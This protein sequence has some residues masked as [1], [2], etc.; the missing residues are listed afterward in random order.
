MIYAQDY[1]FS[2]SFFEQWYE[3]FKKVPRMGLNQSNQSN[4]PYAN[5]TESVKDVYLSFSIIYGSE[6]IYY[7]K[8]IDNCKQL[9]DC[10]D[11]IQTEKCYENVGCERNFNTK[12]AYFSRNLLDCSFVF[13]CV[14]ISKCFMCTNLRNGEYFY[15]NNKYSKDEY[16][17]ILDS[18][19]LNTFDGQEKAKQEFAEL[20]QKAVHRYSHM[21]NTIMSTGDDLRN[22]KNVTKSFMITDSEDV[23]YAVRSPM[24]KN[25]YDAI[26][27]G[28]T[29][30]AYEYM[31]GGATG[32][33]NLKFCMNL[34]PGNNNV[35]YSDYCGSVSDVFG[36][37]GV[38]NKQY[39]IFNK[40]YTKEDYKILKEKIID[41]MKTLSYIDGLGRVY[42]Y[43]ECFPP[44]FSPFAYNESVSQEY[45]PFTKE[46]AIN[47]GCRWIDSEKNEYNITITANSI[48]KDINEV[49]NNITNEVLECKN[50]RQEETLCTGVFRILP[51]ELVFYKNLGIPLPH[52]CPNCRYFERAKF[53][54]PLKLWSRICMC[55]KTTHFHSGN[56]CSNEFETSYAPN[57][58]EKVYCEQCYQQEVI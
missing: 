19:K 42:S 30:Y 11:N 44:E 41:Q 27:L 9:F 58:S 10:Y 3:F 29:E 56:T 12:F 54:N 48:P 25:V 32:S 34:L 15:K 52:L 14:N 33:M 6:Y 13:D 38:R 23:K 47:F 57:R 22:C 26:N 7:S 43:G 1:D 45:F 18:Y 35:E 49:D 31:G 40:Q 51:E 8:N 55:D 2:R 28:K 53:K 5:Y 16:E 39:C 36:C 37:I 21:T 50:K 20:I 46:Q 17:A 4:S 24:I